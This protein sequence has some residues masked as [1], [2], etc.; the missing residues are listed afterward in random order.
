MVCVCVCMLGVGGGEGG[1]GVA[2]HFK[3][4]PSWFLYV[5]AQTQDR[6]RSP[7]PHMHSGSGENLEPSHE[8]VFMYSPYNND[9]LCG[10]S[11]GNNTIAMWHPPDK[12]VVCWPAL[13]PTSPS[14]IFWFSE[15][16]WIPYWP[17][18]CDKRGSLDI[19][20]VVHIASIQ[21]PAGKIP[22]K[23][24]TFPLW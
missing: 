16:L 13:P 5:W 3:F 8:S 4:C 22:A 14:L 19:F 7:S 23:F 11:G 2:A 15:H 21:A 20:A 18:R 10:F 24:G 1:I 6:A 9:P 12:H 17:R